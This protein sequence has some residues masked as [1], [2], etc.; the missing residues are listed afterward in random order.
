MEQTNIQIWKQ[1]AI[2][3]LKENFSKEN[4]LTRLIVFSIVTVIFLPAAISMN[5]WAQH[6][7]YQNYG[8]GFISIS[9]VTNSGM[10]F[11]FMANSPEWAVYMIQWLV[12]IVILGIVL[13]CRKWYYVALW[14]CAFLG[15]L[16]NVIDRACAKTIVSMGTSQI[17][18]NC[19]VDYFKFNF[20]WGIF[21]VPDIFVCVGSIG[22][23]VIYLIESLISLF[24]K[25][26]SNK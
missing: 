23:I 11:S 24:K 8:S 14:S 9:I 1:N 13:F 22:G 16:F 7:P 4:N 3:Y 20:K 5:I 25:D 21:N 26:E 15:G 18:Y 12:T 6:A 2:K 10:A 17:Q 19:V